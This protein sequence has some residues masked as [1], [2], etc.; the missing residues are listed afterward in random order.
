[1]SAIKAVQ[2]AI[3]TRLVGD[4]TLTGMLALRILT[5]APAILND[6]AEGQDYPFV[7]ITGAR[8]RAEHTFGGPSLG[9]GWIVMV[10]IFSMSRY[11]GDLEALT[12]HNR[13]V[14]LLDFYELP[15]TGFAH[16]ICQ[17]APGGDVTGQVLTRDVEKV[18]T[19][20][21]AAEFQVTVS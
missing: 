7:W 6:V 11:A 2:Q 13:I 1:M 12:I 9:K 10:P 5:T 15:V 19:H 8:E 4:A 16:A 21:V 20:Q 18:K 17:Y 3:F 14:A